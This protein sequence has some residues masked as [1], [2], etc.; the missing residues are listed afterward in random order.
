MARTFTS[1]LLCL[2]ALSAAGQS[3]SAAVQEASGASPESPAP[4]VAPEVA[5]APLS[6]PYAGAVIDQF[7]P[8]IGSVTLSRSLTRP[9]LPV[10]EGDFAADVTQEPIPMWYITP[11]WYSVRRPIR[12]LHPFEHRPLYFED[13]A[14]ER[15][16]D[17]CGCLQ[18]GVSFVK[19]S[20]DLLLL[21]CSMCRDRPN[22]C[23]PAG[24][25]CPIELPARKHSKP[26]GT[27]RRQNAAASA[28]LIPAPEPASVSAVPAIRPVSAEAPPRA[29]QESV[30][31]GNRQLTGP[32][33][34]KNSES[35]PSHEPEGI[36]LPAVTDLAELPEFSRHPATRPVRKVR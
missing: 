16:G 28:A 7:I 17:S 3:S 35:E 31:R 12:T 18:P 25:D 8:P 21:P 32:I 5:P 24:R 13:V 15:C 9:S 19:F 4:E 1:Y 2:V 34:E 23:I 33:S 26:R 10:P 22:D 27:V 30:V 11:P 29:E 6:A 20:A 36:L 14:A